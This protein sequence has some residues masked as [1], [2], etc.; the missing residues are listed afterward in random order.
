MAEIYTVSQ[1]NAHIRRMFE[2]E[3]RLNGVT[4]RGEISN[5]KYHSSGHI[6]FTL[7][8]AGGTLSAVLFA[9][10]RR[11]LD[12]RLQDGMQVEASGSVQV[13][14]RSGSYSLYVRTVRRAGLGDLYERFLKL[15]ER[16][17]EM[18]LF[19]EQYKQPIPRHARVIGV[20]TAATGAAVRD[21]IQVSTRRDP[22]VQIVFCPTQ[23]QGQGAAESIVR[24][25]RRLDAYGCDVIIVGRGGGSLEDLWAFN[26]EIVARA[27]FDCATPVISAVGHET[28]FT[29]ADYAADLRAPTPSAA[30]ELATADME[31]FFE[32]MAGRRYSLE[33]AMRLKL[34]GVKERAESGARVLAGYSPA[35]RLGE[36]RTRLAAA[37]LR[38]AGAMREAMTGR[39]HALL[40]RSERLKGLSP[41]EKLA[42]GYA[43]V[44]GPD[45]EHISR[46]GKLKPGDKVRIRFADGNAGAEITEVEH[47]S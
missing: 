28:D 39:R 3:P 38:M 36:S 34:R 42:S 30:A 7:K 27:I 46:A 5:C 22:Y 29:I 17:E 47:G 44:S 15:K 43:W 1:I 23:V 4:V 20:A 21:I 40:L 33:R 11:G 25:L 41:L 24:S 32:E 6:Y 12:F 26:E 31:E 8:D 19:A 37:K 14:E 16:L 13:Y 35:R 2:Q 10:Q 45:G 18:G 9:G